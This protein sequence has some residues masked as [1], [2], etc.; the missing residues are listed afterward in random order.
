MLVIMILVQKQTGSKF[1]VETNCSGLFQYFGTV[2]NPL[3]RVYIG[4]PPDKRKKDLRM[5]KVEELIRL[6]H[7]LERLLLDMLAGKLCTRPTMLARVITVSK[8]FKI[9]TNLCIL[10]Y[11]Q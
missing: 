10:A 9:I 11:A 6:L 2:E 1:L 7:H 8:F 3:E 4:R 5:S